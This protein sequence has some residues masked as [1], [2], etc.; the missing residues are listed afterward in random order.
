MLS[1][2]IIKCVVFLKSSSADSARK[3]SGLNASLALKQSVRNRSHPSK[4]IVLLIKI[5]TSGASLITLYTFSIL[6][7]PSS[8]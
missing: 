2:P 8:A 4:L 1:P 6:H 3:K 7:E 5:G